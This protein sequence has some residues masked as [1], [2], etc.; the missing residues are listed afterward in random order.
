[1]VFTFTWLDTSEN[2]RR[3]T[4]EV[5]DLFR[6]HDTRDELGIGAIRDTIAD[7]LMPGIST[8]QTRARYLLFIPW[9]YQR[10]EHHS[11]RSADMGRRARENELRLARA[12]AVFG[13]ANA[14]PG[15]LLKKLF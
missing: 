2:D 15:P 10:L 9:F 6:R 1:M 5:I 7:L 13:A 14:D 12:L 11:T 3:R 4:M 8:I